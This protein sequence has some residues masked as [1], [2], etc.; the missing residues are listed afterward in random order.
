MGVVSCAEIAE[1]IFGEDSGI[2]G[3]RRQRR[4]LVVVVSRLGNEPSLLV[5]L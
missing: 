4:G 1:I 2:V 5:A 3:V